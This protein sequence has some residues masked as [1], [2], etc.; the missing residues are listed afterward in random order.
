MNERYDVHF[1]S[2]QSI[3]LKPCHEALNITG[4][5]S[6]RLTLKN[7]EIV[8]RDGHNAVVIERNKCDL[9]TNKCLQMQ[10]HVK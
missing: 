2:V 3:N 1:D 10:N 5:S 9:N 4:C 7:L 6:L 8:G